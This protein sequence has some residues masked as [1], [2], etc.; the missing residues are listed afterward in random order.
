MSI[1]TSQHGSK[2]PLNDSRLWSGA[3]ATYPFLP[4]QYH[5]LLNRRH[6]LE[7]ELRLMFAVLEDAIQCYLR[8]MDGQTEKDREEFREVQAWLETPASRNWRRQSLFGFE[9][10]CEA[11]GIEPG[12]LRQRLVS[13]RT[14]N[15]EV[16]RF[17]RAH[18]SVGSLAQP[19]TRLSASRYDS[20]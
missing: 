17:R 11:L 4:V 15:L 6:V 10:L 8:S 20:A 19:S 3:T 14:H 1:S 9:P 13:I 16:K 12:R 7:G 18:R 5:D 2:A